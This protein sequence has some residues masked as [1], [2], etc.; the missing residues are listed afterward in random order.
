MRRARVA[1]RGN[2][3][4]G[5]PGVG[6]RDNTEIWLGVT[7]KKWLLIGGL[8]GIPLGVFG[9]DGLKNIAA[10]G[11]RLAYGIGNILGGIVFGILIGAIIGGIE[12]FI[13]K[14]RTKDQI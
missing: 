12:L 7:M 3:A 2:C 11:D 13:K 10:G 5:G 9:T 4:S 1:T 14:Q 6:C 8:I